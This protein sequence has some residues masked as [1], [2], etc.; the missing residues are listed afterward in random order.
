MTQTFRISDALRC[1]LTQAPRGPNWACSR[2]TCTS[3]GGI[4]NTGLWRRVLTQRKG[5]VTLVWWQGIWLGGLVSAKMRNGQRVWEV[6]HLYLSSRSSNSPTTDA[7]NWAHGD[8]AALE[9]LEQLI[10][11]VGWRSGERIFLRLSPNSPIIPLAR[12]VGFFPYFREDLLEGWGG[13]TTS[14]GNETAPDLRQG[15]SQ[16]QFALFQLFCAATPAR[17]RQVLGLTFD[18]WRDAQERPSKGG[19][20]R[21]T[22]HQGRINGWLRLSRWEGATEGELLTHPDHPDL[23]PS[24]LRVAL[25]RPGWQRWWVPDY[26]ERLANHLRSNDFQHVAQYTMFIK[27]VAAPVSSPGMAPVEA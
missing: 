6:D 9:L 17:L 20:E 12:R 18:Q 14:E 25:A 26:Q 3:N 24:L 11:G 23:L 15:R 4:G 13:R 22:E 27:T 21:V 2:E 19:E 8:S 10:E 5:R 16:D 7:G 1:L